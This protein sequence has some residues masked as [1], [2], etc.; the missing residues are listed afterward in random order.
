LGGG[1]KEPQGG[2]GRRSSKQ[3]K[4]E[5]EKGK[6]ERRI[7]LDTRKAYDAKEVV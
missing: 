2:H 4:Y 6:I 1:P 7:A 5:E 3:R